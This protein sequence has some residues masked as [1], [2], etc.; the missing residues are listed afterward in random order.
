M[1]KIENISIVIK[2][3]IQINLKIGAIYFFNLDNFQTQLKMKNPK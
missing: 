1:C 3:N 2:K